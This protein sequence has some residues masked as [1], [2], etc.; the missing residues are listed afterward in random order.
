MPVLPDGVGSASVTKRSTRG[1][2]VTTS[3]KGSPAPIWW[4]WAGCGAHPFRRWSGGELAGE[5][6]DV[7][8]GG[9]GEVLRGNCGDAA[10]TELGSSFVERVVREHG[11]RSGPC[12]VPRFRRGVWAGSTVDRSVRGGAE[13]PSYSQAGTA[14]YMGKGGSSFE[15]GWRL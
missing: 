5:H 15:K 3:L 13:P 14:G 1:T 12:P 11:N 6:V 8:P 7:R 2:S 4:I 10:G 9:H